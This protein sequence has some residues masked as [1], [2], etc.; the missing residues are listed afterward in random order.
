MVPTVS[1][2]LGGSLR[3]PLS[4]L[5][6]VNPSCQTK[7]QQSG[8]SA[9]AY[10]S[11]DGK[12]RKS[13]LSKLH[14]EGTVK[15]GVS[16]LNCES[17]QDMESLLLCL[18]LHTSAPSEPSSPSCDRPPV[19][20]LPASHRPP[21]SSSI[22]VHS[23]SFSG[24]RGWSR[25]RR[26]VLLQAS[27]GSEAV[28]SESSKNRMAQSGFSGTGGSREAPVLGLTCFVLR[29]SGLPNSIL[30]LVGKMA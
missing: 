16:F 30:P 24:E 12:S 6:L 21:R 14:L 22:P 26:H 5:A 9:P 15:L 29:G 4:D 23:Y 3:I 19:I 8:F 13:I 17:P 2:T 25:A 7:D 11:V 28:K 20:P 1:S 27:L 10:G 18:P